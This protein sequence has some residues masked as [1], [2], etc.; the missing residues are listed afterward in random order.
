[1]ESKYWTCKPDVPGLSFMFPIKG[2]TSKVK[3]AVRD[4]LS[5]AGS[6]PQK[7]CATTQA[8]RRYCHKQATN[9]KLSAYTNFHK[10]CTS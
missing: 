6:S 8:A 5:G 1:M 3:S 2:H 10:G 7:Q 9:L 4:S